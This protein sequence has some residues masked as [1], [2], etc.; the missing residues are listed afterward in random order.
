[1][2]ANITARTRR[3]TLVA[4]DPAVR[5]PHGRIL[6]VSAEIPAEALDPGPWGHRVQVIDF[7]ATTNQLLAPLDSDAYI[8]RNGSLTDP[9]HQASNRTI[10]SDPQFHAQNVYATVTQTLARF[11]RALGRRV[12]WGFPGHQ[13]RVAPHAFADAN[14]FYAPNERALFFG[15]FTGKDGRT[16]FTCLSHDVVVHETTHALVDG[17]RTRFTDP[18]SPDQAAFH[19]GF[20]DCV[21]LLSVFAQREVVEQMLQ[22]SARDKHVRSMMRVRGDQ[23]LIPVDALTH[24]SLA[25]SVLLGLAEELGRDLSAVRGSALRRSVRL[26]ASKTLLDTPEF[27]EPHRRGEI[28]V[29]AVMQT[30]LE[31]W[32]TRLDSLRRFGSS[33]N[34]NRV[35]EEGCAAA[36][37]LLTMLI[38]ALD[39]TPPVHLEFGDFL[40]AVLT[41]DVELRDDDGPYQYRASLLGRFAAFGIAPAS[42]GTTQHP[43]VWTRRS[44]SETTTERSHFEALQHDP[45]EVFAFV[46]ENREALKFTKDAYTRVLSVR[47][48]V[49]VGPDGFVLRETVAEVIQRID[50]TA[51]ELASLGIKKPKMMTG[52]T[53]VALHGG[54]T[55]IFD[56]YGR[57]KFEIHNGIMDKRRQ[58]ARIQYLFDSGYFDGDTTALRPFA[59]MHRRRTVSA[60]VPHQEW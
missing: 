3:L 40:S 35:A 31:V 22:N 11:E 53:P 8:D 4:Q 28:L 51:R 12:N 33:L 25:A 10:L 17:I 18:S 44:A 42:S 2:M 47:P 50:V 19:E 36:D 15:Y 13:L 9:F 52:P 46:W 7:D 57:M 43:G 60:A 48:C 56:E 39:Y 5:T 20:A 59:E 27:A 14:A 37:Y 54:S 30:F 21:A 24:E 38:R 26:K 58:S 41:A 29:A 23:A 55:M 6:C 45:D 49:R 32:E 16:I 34:L 1:M